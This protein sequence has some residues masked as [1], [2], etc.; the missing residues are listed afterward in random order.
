MFTSHAAKKQN[1]KS[2][3]LIISRRGSAAN[4]GEIVLQ[5]AAFC[6]SGVFHNFTDFSSV[7]LTY[8]EPHR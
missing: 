7:S 2:F 6:G 8:S 1:D 5:L 4:A 3:R